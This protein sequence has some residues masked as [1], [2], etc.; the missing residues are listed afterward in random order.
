[1]ERVAEAKA[2]IVEMICDEC[3]EGKM[4]PDGIMLF[5]DPPQYPHKCEK[6]GYKTNYLF[7]YP[8]HRLVPIEPLREPTENEI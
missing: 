5:S 3:K 4:A 2:L 8:F 1:M 7:R 6:C